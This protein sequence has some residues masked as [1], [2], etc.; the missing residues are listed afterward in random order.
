MLPACLAFAT[1]PPVQDHEL[2][3]RLAAWH[4]QKRRLQ[5]NLAAKQV[6]DLNHNTVDGAP[7]CSWCI[8][9][10]FKAACNYTQHELEAAHNCKASQQA[11]D[12]A[13]CALLCPTLDGNVSNA[14]ARDESPY[15]HLQVCNSGS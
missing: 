11:V 8:C 6:D 7:P 3:K 12:Q 10:R 1:A 9:P 15:L 13:T 5:D 2:G 4:T 14:G